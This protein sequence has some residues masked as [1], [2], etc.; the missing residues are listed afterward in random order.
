[1]VYNV[2]VECD[3]SATVKRFWG[4][5]ASLRQGTQSTG[6]SYMLWGGDFNRHH[7][8]WDKERNCYLFMATALREADKLLALVMDYGMEMLLPKDIPTLEVMV[9]KN[10]THPDNVF[11]SDNLG[12]KVIYCTTDLGLRGPGTDHVPILMVLELHVVRAMNVVTYNFHA[13]EWDKFV[14]ELMARTAELPEL[15]EIQSGQNYTDAVSG[16]VQVVQET[17]AAKVPRSKPSPYLK[18]W[19]SKELEG[20]KKKKN[21]V[22]SESY[23]YRALAGHP[24]ALP[25]GSQEN[26]ERI[27]P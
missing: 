4:H 16:L 12:D 11:G 17:I 10:W 20:L 26:Q 23:K 25:Q 21:K 5:L 13:V 6:D 14:G 8:V 24:W 18:R 7:P 9:T 27:Q 1:M 19:W 15:G 3:S 22:S 2:Y